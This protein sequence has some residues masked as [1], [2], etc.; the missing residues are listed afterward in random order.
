MHAICLELY[1]AIYSLVEFPT[2]FKKTQSITQIPP[3][4]GGEWDGDRWAGGR[5][6]ST[7]IKFYTKVNHMQLNNLT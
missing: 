5:A 2:I 4:K 7:F 6:A 3:Y 1:V